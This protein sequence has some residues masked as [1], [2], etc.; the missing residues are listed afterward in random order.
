MKWYR[1]F[2]T[3]ALMIGISIVFSEGRAQ[4]DWR[5]SSHSSGYSYPSAARSPYRAKKADPAAKKGQV[6]D[7]IWNSRHNAITRAVAAVSPAVVGINVT[8]GYYTRR[9]PFFDE[10]FFRYFYPESPYLKKVKSIGS[11]FIFTKDGHI[12][13]NQHV[14]KDAIEIIV[15]VEGG[16]QYVAKKVGEDYTTDI[17]VLKIEGRNFPYAR[18]GNSDD[19]I[20]GEWAI[21]LGNPFGL[22]DISSKATVTVGVISA[23]DQD[24]GRQSNDRI[25]EDMIQTDAAINSGNSGGPLVNC[26]G[27]VIGINTWIISGSESVSASIGIG[28]AIPINRVKRILNDLLNYGR[29]DRSFWTGIQYDRVTPS[30]ARYLG[31]KTIY[32]VIIT[33]IDRGSPAAKAGLKVSDVILSINGNDIHEFHDVERII[34][35]LDLKPGDEMV[36]RIYRNRGI[37]TKTLILE[38]HPKNYRRTYK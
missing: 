35:S 31:L 9:S 14:V 17:A 37:Y 5:G 36:L 27:D 21:A 2:V 29:V 22:F 1:L 26:N 12:L 28:F 33:D 7:E 34:N 4:S 30:V 32:G 20:I 24:F 8:Q 10:P 18:L 3:A 23:V 6:Q 38:S 11:G 19:V 15:T 13:T 16:N 25:F